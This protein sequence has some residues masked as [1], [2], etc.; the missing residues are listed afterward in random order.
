MNNK[1]NKNPEQRCFPLQRVN[2]LSHKDNDWK[3]D[4]PN[5]NIMRMN[6]NTNPEINTNSETTITETKIYHGNGQLKREF[7]CIDYKLDGPWTEYYD[8]GQKMEERFFMYGKETKYR[9][10]QFPRDP[11]RTNL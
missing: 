7:S 5:N 10:I 11:D 6:E 1:E 4:K 8:N 3:T 9:H 2:E